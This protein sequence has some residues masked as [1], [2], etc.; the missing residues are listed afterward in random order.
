M[1][2]YKQPR[3]IVT[4]LLATLLFLAGCSTSDSSS[5]EEYPYGKPIPGVYFG[6]WRSLFEEI[7]IW[8]DN[9]DVY[10]SFAGDPP[11]VVPA[12]VPHVYKFKTNRKLGRDNVDVYWYGDSEG[13][14]EITTEQGNTL[15]ARVIIKD[16]YDTNVI[17]FDHLE[18]FVENK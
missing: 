3:R 2:H 5:Y 9:D 12:D 16:P 1:E 8:Q 13:K 4:V 14:R 6:N 17:L 10:V 18:S 7:E 15:S 11:V